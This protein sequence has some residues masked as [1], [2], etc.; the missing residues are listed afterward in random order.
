MVGE[1]GSGP[2]RRGDE[3]LPTR[4]E[5]SS[6]VMPSAR[7]LGL[8]AAVPLAGLGVYSLYTHF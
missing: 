7:V 8:L 1:S 6:Q 5:V 3:S 2:R 4:P